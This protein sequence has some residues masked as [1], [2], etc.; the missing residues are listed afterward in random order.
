TTLRFS[1]LPKDQ[2]TISIA[3]IQGRTIYNKSMTLENM[4]YRLDTKDWNQGIYLVQ[5]IQS[6]LV[7]FESKLQIK[8][9]E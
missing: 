3:D 8:A 9:N 7:I 1:A 2:V 4:E 5:V 6:N